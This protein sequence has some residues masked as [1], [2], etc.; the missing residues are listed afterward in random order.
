M[1][2]NST[3]ESTAPRR[4]AV[5]VEMALVLPMLIL[6]LLGATDLG[7][8]AHTMV[9]ISNS[10]RSGASFA[11]SHPYSATTRPIWE[12]ETR[13]A[14]HRELETL[15]GFDPQHLTVKIT[16]QTDPQGNR[17]VR[18]EVSYLFRTFVNWLGFP[19]SL[20]LKQSTTFPMIES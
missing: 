2:R 19:S 12:A 20:P 6:I 10:S 18:V 4:G 11:G 5:A 7:R 15:A 13:K 14:V 9:A 17:R 16:P 1:R 3:T 8:F